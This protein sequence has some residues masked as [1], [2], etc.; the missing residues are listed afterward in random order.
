MAEGPNHAEQAWSGHVDFDKENWA[1]LLRVAGTRDH[2]SKCTVVKELE[3]YQKGKSNALVELKVFDGR[4]HGIFNQDAWQGV[5]DCAKHL[6]V[7]SSLNF[8]A[9]RTTC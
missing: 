5:A 3:A 8:P 7:D 4:V 1:L 9:P 2:V 6:C